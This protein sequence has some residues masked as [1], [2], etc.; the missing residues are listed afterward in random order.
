[1]L[2]EVPPGLFDEWMAMDR[3]SPFGDEKLCWVMALGFSAVCDLIK[4]FGG[5]DFES[6]QPQ[7]FIFWEKK[8]KKRRRRRHLPAGQ[9]GESAGFVNPNQA[10]MMFQMAVARGSR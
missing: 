6:T 3:V 8:T 4:S 5:S 7:E 1:M 10:A 9:A 2:A